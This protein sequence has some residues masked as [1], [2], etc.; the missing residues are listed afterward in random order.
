MGN[1]KK[2]NLLDAHDSMF[3]NDLLEIN[4]NPKWALE[5]SGGLLVR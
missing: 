4:D 1:V 3:E 2:K 5:E